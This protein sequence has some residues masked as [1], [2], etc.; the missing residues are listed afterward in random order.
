VSRFR[1]GEFDFERLNPLFHPFCPTHAVKTLEDIDLVALRTRKDL[2][3][4]DVDN[5]I[6]AWRSEDLPESTCEWIE[7]AKE[8]GFEICIISNTRNIPRLERLSKR[9]EID[10][11]AGA[12]FKPSRRLFFKALEKYNVPASRAIMIGDQ[13]FTDVLGANRAG[14]EAVWVEQMHHVD[15]VTTKISRMGERLLRRV[16]YRAL[17]PEEQLDQV[18]PPERDP[19]FWDRPIVRQFVKFGLVGGTSMIIDLG[20][21]RLLMFHVTAGDQLLSTV[22]GEN[23]MEGFP[24]LFAYASRPFDAAFPVFKIVSAGI[25]TLNGFILNRR[26]TFRIRGPQHR[27]KQLA[28]YI[29]VAAMGMLLNTFI[30]TALNSIVPGHPNRSWLVASLVATVVVAFWNFTGQRLWTFRDKVR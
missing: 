16:L 6:V 26:W 5:T 20:L 9:L 30:A 14:I 4:I 18:V 11:V 19:D 25:A 27:K 2:I 17:P 21:H 23:L 22:V 28:K 3:L 13:I 15:L 1:S 10:F 7:R 12:R 8:L 24:G 29:T